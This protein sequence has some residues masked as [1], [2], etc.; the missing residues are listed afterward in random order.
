MRCINGYYMP[1]PQPKA[2]AF[3]IVERISF[4]ILPVIPNLRVGNKV[5]CAFFA[6]IRSVAGFQ[7]AF[8]TVTFDYRVCLECFKFCFGIIPEVI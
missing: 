7:Y 6:V 5:S 2:G 1:K 3:I 4:Y 8:T